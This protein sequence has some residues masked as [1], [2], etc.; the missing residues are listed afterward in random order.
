MHRNL[1]LELLLTKQAELLGMYKDL[2]GIMSIPLDLQTTEGQSWVRAISYRIIQELVEADLSMNSGLLE[3]E[4]DLVAGTEKKI[5][6]VFDTH[7]DPEELVDGMFFFLELVILCDCQVEMKDW[8]FLYLFELEVD[9]PGSDI[10]SWQLLY[11][12]ITLHVGRLNQLLRMRPW[13]KSE[14]TLD[15]GRLMFTLRQIWYF[16]SLTLHKAG[17][18]ADAIE[19]I[20]LDKWKKD[21]LR[22]KEAEAQREIML[23]RIESNP[24]KIDGRDLDA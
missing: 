21:F 1:N 8:H 9:Y 22:A 2:E 20:Y 3:K 18:D 17:L 6:P 11:W 12:Q 19:G 7:P 4:D 5:Y 14:E 16:L 24:V 15:I 23:Q 13:R 10:D